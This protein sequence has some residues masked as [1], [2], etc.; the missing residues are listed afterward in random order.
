[1]NKGKN[2]DELKCR[3]NLITSRPDEVLIFGF[4]RLL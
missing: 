1:M 2:A 4:P 3:R